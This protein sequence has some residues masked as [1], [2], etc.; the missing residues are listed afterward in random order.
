MGIRDIRGVLL[1]RPRHDPDRGSTRP[2]IPGGLVPPTLDRLRDLSSCCMRPQD[3]LALSFHLLYI[4]QLAVKT[5]WQCAVWLFM[6][7]RVE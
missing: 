7:T 5:I 2:Y 3:D 6:V 4:G 1:S